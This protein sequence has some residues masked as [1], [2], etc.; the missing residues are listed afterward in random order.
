MEYHG[1]LKE[2]PFDGFVAEYQTDSWQYARHAN[3]YG[4]PRGG[5]K[6]GQAEKS[7]THRQPG[8]GESLASVIRSLRKPAPLKDESLRNAGN[9]QC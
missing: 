8:Q 4:E 3:E 1:K 9:R 2:W 7:E 5:T 6:T